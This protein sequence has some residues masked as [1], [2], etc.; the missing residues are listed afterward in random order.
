MTIALFIGVFATMTGVQ[1]SNQEMAVTVFGIFMGSVLW[2]F[3]M[4]GTVSIM[5][6]K[7]SQKMMASIKIIAALI[8][9]SFGT[10]GVCSV[11]FL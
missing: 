9:G 11:V 2:A 5:R 8:I 6:H 10:Y 3:V 7:I 4:C 1:L